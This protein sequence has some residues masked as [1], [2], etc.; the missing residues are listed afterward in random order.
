MF[1]LLKTEIDKIVLKFK[2]IFQLGDKNINKQKS[3]GDNIN[4]TNSGNNNTIIGKINLTPQ[5]PILNDQHLQELFK[6]LPDK[7]A[8]I[9]I[10]AINGD[11]RA[12]LLGQQIYTFLNENGF[13]NLRGVHTV[14]VPL[15]EGVQVIKKEQTEYVILIGVV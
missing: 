6:L 10:S 15:T 7:N 11:N 9:H 3:Q 2:M 1:S 4:I 13:S 12:I 8:V 14:F 5:K